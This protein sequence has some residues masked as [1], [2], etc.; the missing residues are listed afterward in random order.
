MALYLASLVVNMNCYYSKSTRCWLNDFSKL[1]VS[2]MEG[3]KCLARDAKEWRK[4]GTI[5][6]SLEIEM[7]WNLK[8]SAWSAHSQSFFVPKCS[9]SLTSFC[10]KD[11]ILPCTSMARPIGCLWTELEMFLRP[12]ELV[13]TEIFF[14][15]LTSSA[16]TGDFF[17]LELFSVFQQAWNS[18]L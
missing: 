1:P 12:L 9:S 6:V 10:I 14:G 3:E 5:R 7:P 4:S 13:L 2:L 8:S 15:K 18:G 16:L 11:G 17:N